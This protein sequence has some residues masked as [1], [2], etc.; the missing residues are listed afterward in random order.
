MVFVFAGELG[1]IE[2]NARKDGR[3]KEN[4][5]NGRVPDKF[6]STAKGV[7]C[8]FNCLFASIS[9]A[10]SSTEANIERL[11]VRQRS[12]KISSIKIKS[13]GRSHDINGAGCHI[14]DQVKFGFLGAPWRSL[15]KGG[16]VMPQQEICANF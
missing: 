1:A 5:G 11:S 8:L 9:G 12:G 13:G 6:K 15:Y 10:G 4:Y 3:G 2:R 16:K 7:N 14:V